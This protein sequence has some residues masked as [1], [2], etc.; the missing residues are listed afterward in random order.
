MKY[1]IQPKINSK[2][3]ILLTNGDRR[4]HSPIGLKRSI[5]FN[6][7]VLRHIKMHFIVSRYS[8]PG[9]FSTKNGYFQGDRLIDTIPLI[10]PTIQSAQRKF[11]QSRE[12]K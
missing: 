7:C 10:S 4:I 11:A 8:I 3:A 6:V 9:Q 2:F 1:R 12:K 5:N